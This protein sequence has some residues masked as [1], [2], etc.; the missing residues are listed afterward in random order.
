MVPNGSK[1]RR[2]CSSVHL[3]ETPQTWRV[4]PSEISCAYLLGG[5]GAARCGRKPALLMYCEVGVSFEG[6]I[7]DIES[8]RCAAS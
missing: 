6:E 7:K 8:L 5:A 2:N 3:K 4:R 1:M